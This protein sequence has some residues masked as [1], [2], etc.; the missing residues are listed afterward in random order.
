MNKEIHAQLIAN[1]SDDMKAMHEAHVVKLIDL[2]YRYKQY[3]EYLW[4]SA[5]Q[6]FRDYFS[7]FKPTYS[8]NSHTPE[9]LTNEKVREFLSD[10]K[11]NNDK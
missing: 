5:P 11:K 4:D 8:N 6:E 9:E 3:G 2:S 7:E 1:M 10:W